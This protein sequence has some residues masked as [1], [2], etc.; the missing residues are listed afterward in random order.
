MNVQHIVCFDETKYFLSSNSFNFSSNSDFV[1]HLRTFQPQRIWF[2]KSERFWNSKNKAIFA[3]IL[4]KNGIGFT[5][6]LAK[7]HNLL[8][9]NATHSDFR[10][11]YN[12]EIKVPN[13]P[14]STGAQPGSK[15]FTKFK[16]I[17]FET[18]K[19]SSCRHE[20]FGVHSPFELPTAS[21]FLE[22]DFD[23]DFQVWITPQ[24]IQTDNDLRSDDPDE[25]NC[26]FDDERKLKYFQVYTQKN[27]EMECLSHVG[28]F[29]AGT[30]LV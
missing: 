15:L 24:D 30:T 27:C 21:I 3:E 23:T 11:S 14:W 6:N 5:F 17:N 26:F 7:D 20:R 28:E 4:T 8:N 22:F 18:W 10:Y 1:E 29:L 16:W 19:Y 2:N 25:R 9:L 13:R 12:D